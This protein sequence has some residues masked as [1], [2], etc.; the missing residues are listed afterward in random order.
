M[1]SGSTA[2]K[3]RTRYFPVE[4]SVRAVLAGNSFGWFVGTYVAFPLA[5]LLAGAHAGTIPGPLGNGPHFELLTMTSLGYITTHISLQY[6][7]IFLTYIK[8]A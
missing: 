5:V 2:P 1:K 4:R 6:V 3:T 7:Y 8:F